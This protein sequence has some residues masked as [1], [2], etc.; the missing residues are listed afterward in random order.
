M[1]I[2]LEHSEKINVD[3]KKFRGENLIP[4]LYLLIGAGVQRRR[5]FAQ[6]CSAMRWVRMVPAYCIELNGR[7][8]VG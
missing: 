5:A 4:A 8:T 6:Q 7:T 2:K 1:C 3:K